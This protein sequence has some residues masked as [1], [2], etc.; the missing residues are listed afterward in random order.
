V[1]EAGAGGNGTVRVWKVANAGVQAVYDITMYAAPDSRLLG[2]GDFN[3]DGA[4]DL[5]WR[6]P[7]GQVSVSL[8]NGAGA[9]PVPLGW[10]SPIKGPCPSP[11]RSPG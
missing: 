3:A 4:T 5:L 1:W 10:R 6:S 8:M 11:H 9:V 7:A 2:T